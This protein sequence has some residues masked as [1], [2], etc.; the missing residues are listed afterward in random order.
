MI[1][2][3]GVVIGAAIL[4]YRNIKKT[5]RNNDDDNNFSNATG[6]SA[7]TAKPKRYGVMTTSE[8]NR[9]NQAASRGMFKTSICPPSCE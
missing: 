3:G 2:F 6:R 7:L 5:P 4:I 9:I 8:R 1:L